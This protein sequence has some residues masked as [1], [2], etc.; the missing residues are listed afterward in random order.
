VSLDV[1]LKKFVEVEQMRELIIENNKDVGKNFSLSVYN[2]IMKI[3][4]DRE[5]PF[6]PNIFII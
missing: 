4:E 6:S 1:I 2:T 5:N 3:E